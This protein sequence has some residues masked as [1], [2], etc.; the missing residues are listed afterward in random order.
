VDAFNV[1]EAAAV[2]R[3]VVGGWTHPVGQRERESKPPRIEALYASGDPGTTGRVYYVEAVREYTL[4]TGG[5]C[6]EVSFGHGW[7]VLEGTHALRPLMFD[8]ML[9]NC[10]RD[11]A[12]YMLPLGTLRV[13]GRL[14]WIGQW[15]GWDDESY[16]VAEI[17]PQGVEW[18]ARK[19]GGGC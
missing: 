2:H 1:A 13:S 19:W 7:F 5:P 4:G 3:E 15:A 16:D 8:V 17:K 9:L 11:R 18:A 14:F 6:V 12:R 10:D